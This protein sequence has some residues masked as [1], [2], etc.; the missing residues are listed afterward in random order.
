MDLQR[1][2]IEKF[3]EGAI[4]DVYLARSDKRP[5]LGDHWVIVMGPTVET[6][7]GKRPESATISAPNMT[8]FLN[9]FKPDDYGA[10]ILKLKNPI[11]F[12]RFFRITVKNGNVTI[13]R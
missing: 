7:L 9:M 8:P 5:A 2:S 3:T 11:P 10:V 4:G 13:P 1:V 12:Y 6:P